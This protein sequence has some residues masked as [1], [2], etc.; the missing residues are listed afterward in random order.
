MPSVFTG[1]QI[2]TQKCGLWECSLVL[3]L[4]LSTRQGS[5]MPSWYLGWEIPGGGRAAM[6]KFV[7]RRPV[8]RR[9]RHT[10]SKSMKGG[11]VKDY[12]WCHIWVTQMAV[13]SCTTGRWCPTCTRRGNCAAYFTQKQHPGRIKQRSVLRKTTG[14]SQAKWVKTIGLK[15][16]QIRRY[17]C[18]AVPKHK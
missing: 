11:N 1:R 16:G 8:D 15:M 12:E 6:P 17:Y 13:K 10:A 3:P 2:R 14:A 4:T 7:H 18:C 5:W 9:L